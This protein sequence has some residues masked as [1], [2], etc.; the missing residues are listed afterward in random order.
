[1]SESFH[2]GLSRKQVE[3][4]LAGET[5]GK[6]P[7]LNDIKYPDTVRKYDGTARVYVRMLSE[8]GEK[9]E[10]ETAFTW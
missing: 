7:Y 4:M 1:M 8:D 5:V 9:K 6:R 2:V 10:P 3:D